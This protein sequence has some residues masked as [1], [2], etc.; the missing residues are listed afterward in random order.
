M[1]L[2]ALHSKALVVDGQRAVLT[3]ANVEAVHDAGQPW[4]DAGF[5]VAGQVAASLRADFE[6]LWRQ[7]TG[8]ALPPLASPG[9]T[10]AGR[11]PMLVAG[12]RADGNPFANG[13]DDP[14]AAAFLAAI[15]NAAV[16]IRLLTPNLN[17]DA[18][19]AALVEAV[20]ER[21]VRVELILPRGFNDAAERAPGRGG[22]NVANVAEL[23]ARIAGAGQGQAALERF[24]ARW[25]ADASGA[26]TDGNGPGAS[27][28]K[29]ATF[30]HQVAIV[31]SGNLDTQ[32]INN[33]RELNVVVDDGATV[34]AWDG[35]LFE[36]S[37]A[38]A[39]PVRVLELTPG[40]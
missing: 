22:T 29:Y 11:I 20:V 28:C 38:R 30:D 13:V 23:Q 5:V 12:R 33:S 9:P 10:V 16:V 40:S 31:G 19:K 4:F 27:H 37:F 14:Q 21:G 25:Y 35:R 18:I 26:P 36:P 1:L 34:R 8:E 24:D 7:V 17:D 6:Q 2:G 15:R 32:A 3:G 39:A